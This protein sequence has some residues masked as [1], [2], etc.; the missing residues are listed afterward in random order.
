MEGSD[1]K[2]YLILAGLVNV[3]LWSSEKNMHSWNA[4]KSAATAQHLLSGLKIR[5]R[6]QKFIF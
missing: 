2:L 3:F 1:Q 5:A 6:N 4:V